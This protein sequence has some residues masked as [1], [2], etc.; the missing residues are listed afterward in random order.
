[1]A[2][3]TRHSGTLRTDQEARLARL[4]DLPVLESDRDRLLH[5][6]VRSSEGTMRSLLENHVLTVLADI[7]RKRLRGYPDTFADSQG[8]AKAARY[9]RKLRGDIESWV[10]RLDAYADRSWRSGYT[11]SAV[12]VAQELSGLLKAALTGT[13]KGNWYKMFRTVS[14]I[15]EDIDRYRRQA[16]ESGD[17]EPSLALLLA[18]LKTTQALPGRSTAAL[19]RCP[20]S[21]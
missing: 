21:I 3:E 19:P 8:T 5:R 16:E 20:N 6:L 2:T 10:K 11:G 17:T 9:A 4:G 13:D 18:Y 14:A 1:M 7:R 12:K 15:R